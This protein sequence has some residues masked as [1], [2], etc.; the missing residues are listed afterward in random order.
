MKQVFLVLVIS[1]FYMDVLAQSEFHPPELQVQ[2]FSN[3]FKIIK[4]TVQSLIHLVHLDLNFWKSTMG[5]Y[6]YNYFSEFSD[7]N[8]IAYENGMNGW[9]NNVNHM[10]RKSY[11]DHYVEMIVYMKQQTGINS[12]FDELRSIKRKY[13]DINGKEMLIVHNGMLKG[14]AVYDVIH[15][16]NFYNLYLN[17]NDQFIKIGLSWEANKI[18]IAP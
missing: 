11:S 10:Y 9:N 17:K 14:N 4:P 3:N 18:G 5:K 2:S 13:Y 1:I 15:L 16:G 7:N 12:F 6:G 8:Y